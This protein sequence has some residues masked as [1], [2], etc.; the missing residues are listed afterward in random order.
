MI[1]PSTPASDAGTAGVTLLPCPFCGARPHQGLTKAQRCQLHGEPFQR[2]EIWCPHTCARINRV[3]REQAAA[4]WNTRLAADQAA[5]TTTTEGGGRWTRMSSP[6]PVG[7]HY[8]VGGYVTTA[9]GRHFERAFATCI[10]TLDGPEWSHCDPAKAHVPL[11]YW[12][13]LG[14]HPEA[15]PRLTTPAVASVEKSL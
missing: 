15:S 9:L 11:Q 13:D 14:A 4:A 10:L 7:G 12:Q 6:P 8:A 1:A 3:N 5:R 2:F